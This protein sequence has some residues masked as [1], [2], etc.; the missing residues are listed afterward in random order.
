MNDGK[1]ER[2]V[3]G[4]NSPSIFISYASP[5]ASVANAV[6][7]ALEDHTFKCWIAPRDVLAGAAYAECIVGAIRES[8]IMV[9]VLSAHAVAS[10]HVARE[11]E[12]GCARK[13]N[14]IPLR[15][16]AAS[17]SLSLEYFLSGCHYLDARGCGVEA[18]FPDLILAVERHM[19]AAGVTTSVQ[20]SHA[21]TKDPSERSP[22]RILAAIWDHLDPP[23][24]HAFSLAYADKLRRGSSRVSTKDFFRAL[25]GIQ[26]ASIASLLD[27]IPRE[28]L[29]DP[30]AVDGVPERQVDNAILLSDCVSESLHRF[31]R[32]T[33][34]PRKLS[35]ADV[36]VDIA[37][38]GHGSSV[39]RL[40]GHGIGPHEVDSAVMRLNLHVVDPCLITGTASSAP[41]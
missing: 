2:S 34:V 22:D 1:S 36:F 3:A 11:V 41:A 24:Q 4:I 38:R 28:A 20:A 32:L 15:T 33:S 13:K 25:R 40:R 14:I 7:A 39:A 6:L 26:G 23:L 16:D 12:C 37:K 9:L 21:E 29:P 18:T 35:P 8:H 31:G 10:D 30:L 5:D 27:E 17:L 19:T